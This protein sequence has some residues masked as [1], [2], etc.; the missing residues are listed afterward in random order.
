MP[1]EGI[2]YVNYG[3]GMS[4]GHSVAV[5]AIEGIDDAI[6]LTIPKGVGMHR[7]L[8][9]VKLKEGHILE[10]ALLIKRLKTSNYLVLQIY[11]YKRIVHL[12]SEKSIYS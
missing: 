7:R 4:M 5:K 3:P 1:P 10:N 11:S 8:V 6:S 2:T 9:Y 12:S